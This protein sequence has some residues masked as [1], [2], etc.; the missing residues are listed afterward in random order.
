MSL[1]GVFT[2]VSPAWTQKLGHDVSEV[3]GQSFVPFIHPDDVAN[4]QAAV[5][6]VLTTGQP[7]D[8]THRVRHKD[9]SWRWHHSVGSLVK[10]Q[11]G[12]PAYFVGVAEDI[13]ERLRAEEMLRTSEDKYRTYINNSPTGVFVVDS[14]GQFVEV[15]TVGCRLLGYSDAELTRMGISDIV[16]AEDL[17][18]AMAMHHELTQTT[19]AVRCEFCFIRKD[20]SR[21]FMSVDAVQV[22]K[23]RSIGFC[24]D[25]TERINAVQ[26]LKQ[27]S[28]ALRQANKGLEEA[29]GKAEAAEHEVRKSRDL[30]QSVIDGIGSPIT[31]ID[32]NYQILLANRTVRELAGGIDPVANSRKCHQISHGQDTP[33]EGQHDPCP[34]KMALE[35]RQPAKVVHRHYDFRGK[36]S[37]VEVTATPIVGD[38]NEIR[39]VIESC[40][41][42][43][44]LKRVETELRNAKQVAEAANRAK[45][46]FLANMSHEIRTPM[47]AILGFTDILLGDL[48][49]EEAI[50]SGRTIKRN[51]EHLLKII[52]D[53]LDLSKIEAE[54]C[55]VDLQKCSPSQIASEVIS[56]MKVRADAKGLPLTLE[57]R[58]AIP[59]KITTDPA[60]LR[61]ILVNMIGNAIKFTEV[62]N[63]R[64]V[65]RLDTMPDSD[66]KLIC[67][68]ID[69]GIGM[70]DEQM[71]LLFRPFSQADNSLTRRF[72]GTGLGL[73][74]SKRMAG[75]LG[76]DIGVRSSP[77]EGSTFSLSIGTGKLDS[78]ISQEPSKAVAVKE[79]V[80]KAK[81][82][83]KL[84][85]RILFAEDGPDNQRLISF[86]LRKAGAEVELAENGQ[87][88]FDLAL[89]AQESGIPFDVILMD[90]QM[91]VMDGYEATRGLR[92]AG[93]EGPIIALTA[94]AMT[95]DRQKCIDAGCDG[96]IT[97]PIDPKKLVGE[98][99]TWVAAAAMPPEREDS[100]QGEYA[101]KAR[102]PHSRGRG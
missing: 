10:N 69:T 43:T 50:E 51:G 44:D 27:T 97:K 86:L 28:E 17:Q 96:Y 59:E 16:A 13:T 65:M 46:E 49:T 79:S 5:Q 8:G 82:A 89:A 20:G 25:I 58:G 101:A 74:I 37:T 11:Q 6:R 70:S 14:N 23:D 9:G 33:C 102:L 91:P 60:R 57:V 80:G 81:A 67:D 66:P 41:D 45:S 75:I 7:H 19:S 93:Y 85:C 2:F 73:A 92:T 15:N 62:G 95:E 98:I 64:V 12:K 90:M 31:L 68:V 63:V 76:G 29:C 38:N 78:V 87:I 100:G 18:S 35:S 47:T 48:V 88:A 4:C 54:K 53:I 61:Q 26:S 22:Q 42:I 1:D 52:N 3:E 83:Q 56:L 84:A 30:L 34:L 24:V 72:G 21:F 36:E 39:Y 94:H 32:R 71:S 99:E 40:Y 77:G 55:T